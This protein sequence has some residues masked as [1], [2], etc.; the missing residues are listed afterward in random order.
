VFLNLVILQ[1]VIDV[2]ELNHRRRRV[3]FIQI[4]HFNL[5]EVVAVLAFEHLRGSCLFLDQIKNTIILITNVCIVVTIFLLQLKHIFLCQ[6]QI[7]FKLIIVHLSL[8]LF[9]FHHVSYK[10]VKTF[11]NTKSDYFG[12]IILDNS[13]LDYCLLLFYEFVIR[14]LYRFFFNYNNTLV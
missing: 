12:A 3:S 8:R 6:F 2:Y 14:V 10:C 9:F 5:V 7:S 13:L 11:K 4:S 1:R